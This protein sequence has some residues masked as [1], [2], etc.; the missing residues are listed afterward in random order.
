MAD[1]TLSPVGF[2]RP[3]I[4]AHVPTE[5]RFGMACLG[6]EYDTAEPDTVRMV[7][8]AGLHALG[9]TEARCIEEYAKYRVRCL[10]SGVPNEFESR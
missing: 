6:G 9:W 4:K 1:D 10:R 3:F 2:D 7:L 8:L 5:A